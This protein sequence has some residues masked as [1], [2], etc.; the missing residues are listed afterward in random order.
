MRRPPRL[1]V[2]CFFAS[3]SIAAQA[4]LEMGASLRSR[5]SIGSFPFQAADTER[6]LARASCRG[7]TRRRSGAALLRALF[8]LRDR[9]FAVEVRAEVLREALVVAAQP[10]QHH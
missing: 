9:P 8:H 3:S 1:T 6:A 4:S 7:A 5:S 2:R 10:L